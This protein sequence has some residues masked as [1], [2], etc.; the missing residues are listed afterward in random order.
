MV[1]VSLLWLNDM[2]KNIVET[3]KIEGG[4]VLKNVIPPDRA[5]TL[6]KYVLD[7]ELNERK[8]TDAQKKSIRDKGHRISAKGIGSVSKFDSILPE[9]AAY[10]SDDRIVRAA[11]NLLGVNFRISTIGG[12]VN[13]PGNQRGYW[14]S[15][16]PFNQT[17][18]SNVPAPYPNIVMHLSSLIMLTEF[19]SVTGGTLIVPKS[20]LI[21]NNP[22][23][24]MDVDANARHPNEINVTGNPGDVFFYDSRLWHAVAENKGD[25]PRVAIS[26]RYA[27][28]WLN[29]NVQ[30]DGHR[31]RQRIV[32]DIDGKDSITP[33][34][35]QYTY[36]KLPEKAKTLFT[37]LVEM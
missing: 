12:L 24:K 9:L 22:S 7:T 19:S 35:S 13:F 36:N 37:H 1:P 31:D 2:V 14:H 11:E 28:W 18:A 16:W 15:D 3:V 25:A 30:Q 32:L 34:I 23:G 26:V 4:I 33:R 20:H 17:V 6:A 27:P 8:N 21:P 10:L 29:L 5:S